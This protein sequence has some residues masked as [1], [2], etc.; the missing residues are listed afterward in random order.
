[1]CGLS[2]LMPTTTA[3]SSHKRFSGYFKLKNGETGARICIGLWAVLMA[4][5]ETSGEF[6][7]CVRPDSQPIASELD[8]N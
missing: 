4:K 6:L 3:A 2:Y 5:L 7:G 1:M 8:Y